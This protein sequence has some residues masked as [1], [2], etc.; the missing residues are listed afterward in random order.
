MKIKLALISS[1]I[2][3]CSFAA[4]FSTPKKYTYKDIPKIVKN[5][6]YKVEKVID[7][8]TFEININKKTYAV[9]M[10]GIDT[11]ETVDPRKSVQC[12]GMEAS[13]ETKKLLTTH[14][15]SFEIDNTRFILDKYGRILAYVYRDDGLFVNE[16][17]LEKGFAREYTYGKAYQKKKEFKKI[18]KEAETNKIG[19]WKY[20]L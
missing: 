7:G 12:Y 1:I 17:L 18:E 10:L 4:Y 14:S 11:P 3:F 5:D 6:K 2:I 9:R 13:E 16:Y 15:V 20:C 19:L 8:D